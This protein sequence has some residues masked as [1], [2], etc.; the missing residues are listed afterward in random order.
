MTSLLRSNHLLEQLTE[1]REARTCT[2]LLYNKGYN[3]DIE[4]PPDEGVHRARSESVLNAE[5]LSLRNWGVTPFGHVSVFTN[6]EALQISS[7]GIFMESSSWTC[8]QSLAQF[9]APLPLLQDGGV[10]LRVPGF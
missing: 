9:P 5:L 10:R 4:Q 2:G 3:K 7:L 8:D 1:V 6:P